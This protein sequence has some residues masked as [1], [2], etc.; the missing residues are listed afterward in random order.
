MNTSE[1]AINVISMPNTRLGEEKTQPWLQ[2]P[3]R[4]LDVSEVAKWLG[5]STGW[6]RDHASGRRQPKLGAIK[7]GPRKGK[8]LWKFREQDVQ[9]FILDQ[10]CS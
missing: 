9:Q 1:P 2:L 6:V 5:V 10:S 7:L 4:L 8:G 3:K